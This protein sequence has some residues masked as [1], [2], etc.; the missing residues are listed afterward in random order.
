L[1]PDYL[2]YDDRDGPRR[3]AVL[4]GEERVV[5]GGES[6]DSTPGVGVA[7]LWKAFDAGVTRPLPWRREQLRGITAFLRHHETG[8]LDALRADL[9]KPAFEAYASDVGGVLSEVALLERRLQQL[10]RPRRIRTPLRAQPAVTALY[11]EPLGVV[12]VLSA[13]NYPVGL[14]LLAVAGALSAGNAVALKPSEVAPASA[15][16]LADRLPSF[17]DPDAVRVFEG[18]AET[19][20]SLL[21]H[22]FAHIHYTGSGRVAREVMRAAAAHLTPVTLELGGKNPAYVH[23]GTNLEIAARRIFWGRLFNAG[24]T[25]VSPDYVLVDR[26]LEEPLL[27]A[28]VAWARSAY[29]PEP[30]RSPDLARIVNGRHH[31]RLVELLD[32]CG[33]IVL[34]G[35]HDPTD[36]YFAP[37]IVRGVADDHPL[38][39]EEIFGP[40]LPVVAV[41]GPDDAIERINRRPQPLTM[42]VFTDDRSVADAV[43]DRTS[44]GSV[45]V[46]QMFT[47]ALNPALPFGGV[48]ESGMGSYTGTAS[49][50][51]FSHLKP[52]VRSPVRP[53]LPLLYP[54][55][56][57]W[58]RGL[59]R[60]LL[61]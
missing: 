11:P 43:V 29:G 1:I 13:W 12:L 61:K 60:R 5:V 40:I 57:P 20:G 53:D 15:A 33:E 27:D 25:C 34:G 8:I 4:H 42:Y 26:D 19:A 45:V 58:K 44:A 35:D 54:P 46:N 56:V 49:F 41:D 7:S 55:Y 16:L 50:D 14:S 22:R 36:R 21:A 24:Q 30:R 59:V 38:M 9:G 52:V 48:G 23:T 2:D 39:Q 31:A 18:G 6:P 37:T 17:V 3:V 28:M 32:G 47:Q 51:C 10:A